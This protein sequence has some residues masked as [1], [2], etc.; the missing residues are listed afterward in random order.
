MELSHNNTGGGKTGLGS[1]EPSNARLPN[2]EE[3]QREVGFATGCRP[4]IAVGTEEKAIVF[5][6][7]PVS[8]IVGLKTCAANDDCGPACGRVEYGFNDGPPSGIPEV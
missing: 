6:E 8:G 2:L 3:D 5:L 4:D 1:E 7:L